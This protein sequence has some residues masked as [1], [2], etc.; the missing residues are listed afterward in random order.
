MF[1]DTHWELEKSG[2]KKSMGLPFAGE[3]NLYYR[4]KSL[5]IGDERYLVLGRVSLW[6]WIIDASRKENRGLILINNAS[7]EEIRNLVDL[8]EREKT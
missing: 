7:L 2:W 4:L 1:N 6:L 5:Q 8:L 3:G